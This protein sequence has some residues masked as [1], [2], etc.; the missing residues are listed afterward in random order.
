MEIA[1]H[2]WFLDLVY[3]GLLSEH[4]SAS[5]SAEESFRDF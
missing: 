5:V 4:L 1:V 2:Q 3:E